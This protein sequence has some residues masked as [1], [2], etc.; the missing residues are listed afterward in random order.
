[1]GRARIYRVKQSLAF[2]PYAYIMAGIWLASANEAVRG[3]DA[4]WEGACLGRAYRWLFDAYDLAALDIGRDV[5]S[6]T[7]GARP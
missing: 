5:R 6:A 4:K 7:E 2:V 3:G 1:M